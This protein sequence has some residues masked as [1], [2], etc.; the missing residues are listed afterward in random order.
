MRLTALTIAIVLSAGAAQAVETCK[1][2]ADGKKLAG[3]ARTSFVTKCER[4]ATTACETTAAERKLFGAAKNSFVT[5][6]SKDA[7][8]A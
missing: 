8:G 7:S 3:A 4:D 5:K 2:Q 1:D 6:C